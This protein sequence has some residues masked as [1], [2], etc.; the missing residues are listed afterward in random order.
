V[1]HSSSGGHPER[2]KISGYHDNGLEPGLRSYEWL[3]SANNDAF[4]KLI[5]ALC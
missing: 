3:V 5:G 1:A 2:Q 4:C